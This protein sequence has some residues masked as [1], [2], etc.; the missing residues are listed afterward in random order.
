LHA[1]LCDLRKM[2]VLILMFRV[3]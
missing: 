2:Y 1:V 3:M